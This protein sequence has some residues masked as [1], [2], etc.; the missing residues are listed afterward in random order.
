[1]DLSI[2]ANAGGNHRGIRGEKKSKWAS[3]QI[4]VGIISAHCKCYIINLRCSNMKQRYCQEKVK[5][6]VPTL[7]NYQ[8]ASTV[9]TS[10]LE[11]TPCKTCVKSLS[12]RHNILNTSGD[13][14]SDK[15]P[16]VT[17]LSVYQMSYIS[18]WASV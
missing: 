3:L 5:S 16:D 11:I 6:S 1:M 9:I 2:G 10:H 14:G 7:C 13:D 12:N 4:S 18:Q 17:C 15:R 8:L